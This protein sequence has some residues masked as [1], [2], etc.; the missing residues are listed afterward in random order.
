MKS[1]SLFNRQLMYVYTFFVAIVVFLIGILCVTSSEALLE[2]QLGNRLSLGL[3]IFWGLRLLFQFFVY[4]S[5]L[6]HGKPLETGVH[7]PFSFLWIYFSGV[8]SIVFWIGPG[9]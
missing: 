8:F 3:F 4:S 9:I 1:I 6:W 2:T 5:K 7:I